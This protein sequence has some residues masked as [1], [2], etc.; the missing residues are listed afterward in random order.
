LVTVAAGDNV[1]C[2]RLAGQAA[3]VPVICSALHSTG[4]PDGVGR[5][6]RCLTSITDA[7]IG[8]AELHGRHL[9]EQEGFP[10]SKVVVIPNGVDTDRF[11]PGIDATSVRRELGISPTAPVATILAALRPEKNHDLFLKVARMVLGELNDAQFL[12]VGDGPQRAKLEACAG[13]LGITSAVKFLGTRSDVPRILSATDVNVLTSHIEANPVSILEAM[14]SGIPTVA[15]DVGSVGQ[16]VVDGHTGYLAPAGDASRIAERVIELLVDPIARQRMGDTARAMVLERWS[17]DVMVR[18]YEQ[19]LT[20]LY[21]AKT[22]QP[23]APVPS[24]Q[25]QQTLADL[26]APICSGTG[27]Y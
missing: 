18:G 13:E 2:G 25:C 1:F 20:R 3:G 16:S 22:G 8:V 24:G 11:A 21:A 27:S 7:F 12:V 26:A 23:V 14:S 19:L 6:N 4:W 10:A 15:T 9:V 5:L 17:L